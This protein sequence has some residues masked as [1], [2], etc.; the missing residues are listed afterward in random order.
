[1]FTRTNSAGEIEDMTKWKPIGTHAARIMIN[2]ARIRAGMKPITLRAVQR[3]YISKMN[4]IRIGRGW[5]F[6]LGD[7]EKFVKTIKRGR[8]DC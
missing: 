8:I 4:G 5:V 1:M 6:R 3:F 7:V 2:H